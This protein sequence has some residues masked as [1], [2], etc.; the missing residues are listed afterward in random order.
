MMYTHHNRAVY[1]CADTDGRILE[2]K[3]RSFDTNKLASQYAKRANWREVKRL[4][5]G[6][7]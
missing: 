7:K 4:L 2:K 5:R 3:V 6:A 1:E